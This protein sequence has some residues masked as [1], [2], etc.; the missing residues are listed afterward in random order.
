MSKKVA[1]LFSGGL[2][3][4]YLVWKN[5]TD[6]NE[7]QPVYVEIENNKTKTILEKNRTKLLVREFEK[8]FPLKIREVKHILKV[9]VDA[10][11]DSLYFKQVPVWMLAI[12]FAQDLNV[13]E[14]QIGYVANDDAIGY[15]QD[16]QNAYKAYEPLMRYLKPLAFPL[17]KKPKFEMARELP[18]NYRKFI[19][20]CEYATIIG[21]ETAEFIEYEPCCDC[22]PCSH[23]LQ[24]GYYG[25]GT[26]PDNYKKNLLKVRARAVKDMGYEVVDKQGR[27]Y[28]YW[29]GFEGTPTIDGEPMLKSVTP[30]QIEITFPGTFKSPEVSYKELDN[31]NSMVKTID[32]IHAKFV[33]RQLELEDFKGF[34][35]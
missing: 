35:G 14:I 7:V 19:F 5:L 30:Y 23:A 9:N 13:D 15:L 25:M 20:S 3:S 17:S 12:V 28:D 33:P 32:E 21:S 18:E 31:Y 4:T 10:Q 8:E 1:V 29:N 2:D 34:N 16:I 24:N 22:I 11:E 6:G 26:I 27:K